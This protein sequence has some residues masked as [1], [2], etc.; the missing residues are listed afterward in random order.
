MPKDF[1][2]ADNGLHKAHVHLMDG[3]IMVCLS[4]PAEDPYF[5][6]EPAA[7]LVHGEAGIHELENTKI[8]HSHR[9]IIDANWKLVFENN[10]ECYHCNVG[11]PEYIKS[12]YDTAFTY[13]E[14]GTRGLE[15]N[16]PRKKK[17]EDWMKQ[18]SDQWASL[19]ISCTPQNNFP[20]QGWY[21][22]SRQPLREDWMVESLDGKPVSKKLLGRC[23]DYDMG[24]LRLHFLPNYWVHISA[25]HAVSTRLVPLTKDTTEAKVD[26]LVH[27]DAVEGEDYNLEDMLPFW[28]RTSEQDWTLCQDNQKGVESSYYLPG[29]LSVA[30]EQGLEK[31]IKFYINTVKANY[32]REQSK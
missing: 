11:H 22:A 5:D 27:K 29:R 7:K 31:F 20:G 26:W 18:K 23:P 24:S 1:N 25:D 16:H 4:N 21:R 9:Y 19:G 12:N 30:K 8:A 6:V 14:D 28:Q 17:I 32:E 13:N 15:A 10:R 3:H 2:F